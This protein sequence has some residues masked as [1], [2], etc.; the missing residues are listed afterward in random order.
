[1]S[2]NEKLTEILDNAFHKRWE[3]Y[4]PEEYKRQIADTI[5]EVQRLTPDEKKVQDKQANESSG[6]GNGS[7]QKRS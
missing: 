2:D 7:L 1:M 5:S 6:A 3:I 4:S